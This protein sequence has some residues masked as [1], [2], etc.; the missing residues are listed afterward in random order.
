MHDIPVP[1]LMHR[2]HSPKKLK[3]YVINILGHK[4]SKKLGL[5]MTVEASEET[6]GVTGESG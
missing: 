1:V 4:K 2:A 5:G 6:S 3:E